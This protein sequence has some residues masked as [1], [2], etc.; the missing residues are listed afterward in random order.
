MGE[1]VLNC[2]ARRALRVATLQL[3]LASIVLIF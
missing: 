2:D 1:K 3:K